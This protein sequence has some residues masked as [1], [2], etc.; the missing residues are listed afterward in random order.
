MWSSCRISQQRPLH[1]RPTEG[2][3]LFDAF[4]CLRFRDSDPMRCRFSGS[5]AVDCVPRGSVEKQAEWRRGEGGKAELSLTVSRPQET[6]TD[7]GVSLKV[8]STRLKLFDV[9]PEAYLDRCIAQNL[10]SES[11]DFCTL[12]V[13]PLIE[14]TNCRLITCPRQT[15]NPKP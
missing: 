4:R 8:N 9:F 13:D 2:E 14:V 3:C 12:G 15:L 5:V 11:A 1:T 7:L 6:D 10:T